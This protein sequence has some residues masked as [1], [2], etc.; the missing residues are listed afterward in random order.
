MILS[1]LSAAGGVALPLIL[2]A[3]TGLLGIVL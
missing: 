1:T 2:A 3:I